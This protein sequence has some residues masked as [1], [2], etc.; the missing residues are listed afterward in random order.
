[1]K[2]SLGRTAIEIVG[3]DITRL[4]VDAIANDAQTTLRMGAGVAGAI[5]RV[6]GQQIEEEALQLG[7][8]EVGDAVV[9]GGHGL[10]ARWVVHAAV[11]GPDLKTDADAI[12]AGTHSA[13]RR[14]DAKGA[15]SVALPAFGAG[16][17]GFPLYQGAA[18]IVD[19]V[20]RYLK[21]NPKTKL[22]LVVLC[23]YGEHERAAFT[24]ALTG[25]DHL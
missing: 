16:L 8:I 6:G 4:E 25:I 13:L 14:A 17:G 20:A 22:R 7:P 10:K 3:G 23:G 1:M 12:A 21:A 11:M 18:I 24:H 19:A 9:T 2:T 15:R 5:R